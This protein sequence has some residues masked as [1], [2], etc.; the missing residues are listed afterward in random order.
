MNRKLRKLL[1]KPRL[2][3]LDA[4]RNRF[5][6]QSGAVGR[7]YYQYSVISAVY[8]VEKYLDAYFK[9]LVG[10]SIGFANHIELILVDDGSL[11]NSAVI[12]KR[13]Q[14]K[15]PQNI[16]YLR[17]E[18][19]G[20]ASARNV[21]LL[22]ATGDW[23]TFTD[24]DDFLDK[25]Y[26]EKVDS[27]LH[28]NEQKD[29]GLVC[30][31]WIFYFEKGKKFK[32]SHPLNY[33]FARGNSVVTQE[34][35]N[36]M[37]SS[38][39]TSF[40]RLD[41]LSRH[42]H[43]FNEEIK[44][45]FEDGYF[46]GR[47]LLLMDKASVA[48][49]GDA[50]YYYRK[51]RDGSSTLDSSWHHPSRFGTVIE[52]GYLGL[53]RE[54]KE[55][56]G[57]VPRS[58]QRFILYD[59]FWLFKKI[60]NNEESI[61]F[62]SQD[63]KNHFIH[64]LEQVFHYIDVST[65]WSFQLAGCWF[66]H[67]IGLLGL[68]KKEKPPYQVIYV[69][70][71]DPIKKLVQLS[72]FYHG[73]PPLVQFDVHGQDVTPL[74]EKARVHDFIGSVFVKE[75]I[76]WLHFA[77]E[78]SS[79]TATFNGENTRISLD[80][81]HYSSGLNIAAIKRTYTN[82]KILTQNLPLRA[83]LLLWLSKRKRIVRRYSTGWM[84]MDRDTQADDN[85]E[86]LYSYIHKHHPEIPAF[87]VLRK[88]SHDWTR[89]R[90]K[91]FNLVKYGSLAHCYLLLNAR[92]VISSHP[93]NFVVNFLP[94]KIYQDFLNFKFTFLQHGIIRDDI[95]NWLNSKNIDLFITSSPAEHESVAGR[96]SRYKFG[97]FETRLAGLSR[98]DV[99]LA[100][101]EP[102]ENAILI[103][104]TWRQSL[105]GSTTRTSTRRP[106]TAQFYKSDYANKWKELL[107]SEIFKN[108]ARKY[109][110]KVI[111]FPHVNMQMYLNWF[112][113]PE[114]IETRNHKT[115]PILQ[116]L[117]RRAKILITD[118]SSVFFEMGLLKKAVLYYQ[119]DFDLMYGGSHPSR[120]GYFDFERDGFGPVTR[121]M[122]ELETELEKILRSG[123]NPSHIYI[124]RMEKA[125]A[126]RDGKNSSRTVQAIRDMDH[127][128]TKN[129]Q[130][131]EIL[132]DYAIRA[133]NRGEWQLAE[134]RWTTVLSMAD[135]QNTKEATVCL[136][137][138]KRYL[139]KLDECET[140][141]RSA[142]ERH[143]NCGVLMLE[144]AEIAFANERWDHGL[145]VLKS[146]A[147]GETRS[148]ESGTSFINLRLAQVFRRLNRF[149]ESEERLGRVDDGPQKREER[150][151]LSIAKQDWVKLIKQWN[152]LISSKS[153]DVS[154]S[155]WFDV[156]NAFRKIN[157]VDDADK[158]LS[159]AENTFGLNDE[160][161]T[162]RIELNIKNNNLDAARE[163][164][165]RILKNLGKATSEDHLIRLSR[166]CRELNMLAEASQ[167]IAMVE[168]KF[169]SSTQSVRERF[170]LML[171]RKQWGDILLNQEKWDLCSSSENR[172]YY[173]VGV[174]NAYFELG[175]QEKS[176][177]ILAELYS[178]NKNSQDT[179]RAYAETLHKLKDWSNAAKLWKLHVNKFPDRDFSYVQERWHEALGF[180]NLK[181]SS[182]SA[183]DEKEDLPKVKWL[184]N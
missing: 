143:P 107:H 108:L 141:L 92:H 27:F 21:G 116:K 161:Q 20:Q 149:E 58:L 18:N 50:I 25:R 97:A 147:D 142:Q 63:Q 49:V 9:S 95:S 171:A 172:I 145:N 33:R 60:I 73:E 80:G 105:V 67:K 26:F 134:S 124:E 99:L 158:A 38:T 12:V 34:N 135:L 84:L 79:F 139:G 178:E 39:A 59:A 37:A 11:D 136:L 163:S 104:P 121:S 132:I 53:L 165:L 118:Y 82:P 179:L 41:I 62:L 10:Q 45:N 28:K 89:L 83:L 64:L 29:I 40:Y 112:N 81:K 7:G 85:A 93:D 151:K 174:A 157:L 182:T 101:D 2:F 119:F 129:H 100:R 126:H 173:K 146:L 36:F 159:E 24:P 22:C 91:G 71:Y 78:Y 131:A 168:Q 46:S 137:R 31:K 1:K 153:V 90:K 148:T 110:Y 98:H 140:L 152:E 86:R 74:F 19:G 68:M 160:V 69:N 16:K 114:W 184:K 13:W 88:T 113:A 133:F 117:Y 123:G 127:P 51:R 87:F 111:F 130:R 3:F 138:A 30:C 154:P 56:T 103:M 65:I 54:A 109:N 122:K 43:R 120:L 115:D 150:I 70:D 77:Q 96:E 156:I 164:I 66:Y 106:A 169:D 35:P 175:Q 6:N 75:R 32:N 4:L 125:F 55:K 94:R 52:K 167:V 57:A 5:G 14:K 170:E 17:K 155:C 76:L 8:N 72:F 15:Y 176:V 42:R 183:I 177:K 181:S 180:I 144:E 47:Y 44:P 48:Y 102:T 166:A 61:S 162:L 23:V 128:E